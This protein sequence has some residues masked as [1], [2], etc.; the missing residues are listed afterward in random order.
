LNNPS[1]DHWLVELHESGESSGTYQVGSWD[2][3]IVW[4][5]TDPGLVD[6]ISGG[7]I[8]CH[9]GNCPKW[10]KMVIFGHFWPF[11]LSST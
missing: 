11:S 10:P 7:V 5:S 8:E 2:V 4:G 3:R 9:Q 1:E 6:P